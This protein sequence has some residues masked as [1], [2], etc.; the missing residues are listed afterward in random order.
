MIISIRLAVVRKSGVGGAVD[1]VAR[2]AGWGT[3]NASR[4]DHG[5]TVGIGRSPVVLRQDWNSPSQAKDGA[6]NDRSSNVQLA[7][8]R[9]VCTNGPGRA[10]DSPD[11]A[12]AAAAEM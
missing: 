11:H 2:R 7:D 9:Q 3:G 10:A 4:R 8:P 12:A 1:G 5:T 6:T